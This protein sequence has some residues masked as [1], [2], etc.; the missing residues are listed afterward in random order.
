MAIQFRCETCGKLLS[1]PGGSGG[2]TA[3]CPECG[4]MM[5][6]PVETT[7]F[8][9][10]MPGEHEQFR[11]AVS[12]N[13][14][15][16]PAMENTAA[17]PNFAYSGVLKPTLVDVGDLFSLTWRTIARRTGDFV[18]LAVI[19][20]LIGLG[21]HV[22]DV[23]MKTVCG[24][25]VVQTTMP[26][27]GM[28]GLYSIETF[29]LPYSLY[30]FVA[31][32]AL[33]WIDIGEIIC[34]L[35][36]IRGQ[37][38]D[39]ADLVRGGPFLMRFLGVKILFGLAVAGGLLLLLFPAVI[40][41]LMFMISKYFVIDRQAGVTEAMG[42]SRDFMNGNKWNVFL[43]VILVLLLMIVGAFF[44]CGFGFILFAPILGLAY[45]TIYLAVTGQISVVE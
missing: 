15:Q 35:K 11:D 39:Y 4:H 8:G 18:I 12:D 30:G 16:A 31:W 21:F 19:V 1:V 34:F 25:Q 41:A 10:S 28:D 43:F 17:E 5:A 45:A 32:I 33:F 20:V 27:R 7:S 9:D 37:A 3:Q 14:Y 2:K 29:S 44:T 26:F 13:P 38:I 40:F 23:V 6:V 42:L 22:A 24:M 36:L